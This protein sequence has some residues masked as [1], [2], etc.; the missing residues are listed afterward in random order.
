MKD[1]R[2][3]YYKSLKILL[4]VSRRKKKLERNVTESVLIL[5]FSKKLMT[6]EDVLNLLFLEGMYQSQ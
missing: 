5:S 3:M 4:F 6:T 2:C 1:G